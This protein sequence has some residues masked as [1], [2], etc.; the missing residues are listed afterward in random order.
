MKQIYLKATTQALLIADIAKVM[1]GYN[2]EI[3]FSNNEI[4]GHWIGQIPNNTNRLKGEAVTFKE[5]FHANLLVPIDF[6]ESIFE[7]RVIPPPENPV[8]QFA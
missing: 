1:D 6:D 4:I 3:E 8:H 7:T 2:G 5:G